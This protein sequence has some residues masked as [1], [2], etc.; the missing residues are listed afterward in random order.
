M[1]TPEKKEGERSFIGVRAVERKVSLKRTSIYSRIAAGTFPRPVKIA[2]RKNV[3]VLAEVDAWLEAQA[4]MRQQVPTPT[5]TV[6]RE[7]DR[8]LPAALGAM[9]TRR[10]TEKA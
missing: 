7:P 2:P 9:A 6:K 1:T 3:W 4:A 10:Q 8:S 5:E